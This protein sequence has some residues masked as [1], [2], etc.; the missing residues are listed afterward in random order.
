MSAALNPDR[1]IADETVHR[2]LC[3]LLRLLAT[4]VDG[5]RAAA[6]ARIADLAR[7]H[8]I[9]WE[10]VI[11]LQS[12]AI[13]YA[14][15]ETSRLQAELEIE[16]INRAFSGAKTHGAGLDDD[17]HE[18]ALTILNAKR[19]VLNP[20]E[21]DFL[22]DMAD[23]GGRLSSRQEAWLDALWARHERAGRP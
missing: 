22:V 23:W 7:A 18:R 19:I 2:R 14:K 1:L 8:C 15:R 9:D 13:A 11:P 6:S 12:A 16:R 21:R 17:P 3:S 20:K 4:D 5:E 10:A